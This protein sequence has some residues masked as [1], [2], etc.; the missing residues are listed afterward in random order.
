MRR[1]AL[2]FFPNLSFVFLKNAKYYGKDK[3]AFRV[4]IK[5][6]KP[7]IKRYVEGLYGVEV[8]KVNTMNYEGVIRRSVNTR[9][10]FRR[11]RYKKAIVTVRARLDTESGKTGSDKSQ[12]IE[13]EVV[14][15]ASTATNEKKKPGFFPW[16]W[17]K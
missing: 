13:A 2:K 17:R 7:E 5:I 11:P 14:E 4:P 3:Y 16:N 9:H 6:S 12:P 1:Q 8:T 15:G 10:P